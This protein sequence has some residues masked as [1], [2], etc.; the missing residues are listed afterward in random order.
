MWDIKLNGFYLTLH[1]RWPSN[2]QSF[3]KPF[4]DYAEIWK[5]IVRWET[6]WISP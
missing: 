3:L 4:I 1:I 5:T 2:L 6:P